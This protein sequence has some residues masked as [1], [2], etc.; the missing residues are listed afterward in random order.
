[1]CFI[2]SE[3]EVLLLPLKTVSQKSN[4]TCIPHSPVCKPDT[5][6]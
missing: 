5:I 4:L 1:M 6:C 2:T 3:N